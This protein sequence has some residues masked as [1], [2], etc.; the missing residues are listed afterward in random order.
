MA[1]R[2]DKHH[3][4]AGQNDLTGFFINNGEFMENNII[5]PAKYRETFKK[6]LRFVEPYWEY[7]AE[8][9]VQEEEFIKLMKDIMNE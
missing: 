1:L 6:F 3:R 8:Y 2:K 5:I 4:K 9:T 7:C